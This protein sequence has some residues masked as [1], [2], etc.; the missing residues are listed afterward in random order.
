MKKMLLINAVF[1][2]LLCGFSTAQTKKL[3]SLL[4]L[5]G[6][7]QSDLNKIQL[8]NQIA[9][10]YVK[11]DN[12][13]AIVYSEMSLKLCSKKK[14]SEAYHLA[15]EHIWKAL[16]DSG[17]KFYEGSIYPRAL[18]LYTKALP[19]SILSNKEVN[20]GYAYSNIGNV[21]K[22]QGNYVKAFEFYSKSL[23]IRKKINDKRT[24][25]IAYNN[26]GHVYK[27]ISDQDSYLVNT[28]PGEKLNKALSCYEYALQLSTAADDKTGIQASYASIA[29]IY[30]S[31]K[32]YPLALE[33]HLKSLDIAL[34]NKGANKFISSAY[35]NIG[36]IYR[37]QSRDDFKAEKLNPDDRLKLMFECFESAR[38][39]AEKTSDFYM[40]KEAYGSL[41]AYFSE[42]GKYQEAYEYQKK[43]KEYNDSIY[44]SEN[45][46][47]LSAI[48]TSFEAEKREIQFSIEKEKSDLLHDQQLK[49]KQIVY[50]FEKQAFAQK[51]ENDK[52]NI[53]YREQEKRKRLNEGFKRKKQ[54]DQM[55]KV[56]IKEVYQL[57]QK[58]KNM[59]IGFIIFGLF[60]VLLFSFFIYRRFR[61][62]KKQNILIEKQKKAVETQKHLVEEKNKE[63]LDS[64]TYAKRIQSAILPQPKLVKEYFK[65]S[66][67]LYKPKDIVAGDFYWFEVVDDLIFFA[68]ADCTGH[69]VPGALVSVVC[70]NALNRSVKEY[71]LKNPAEILDKTREVVI[72]E[73]EKSDEDVKDGMDISLCTVNMNTLILNWS[74]AHNPLW[75]LR[76]GEIIEYKADKQPI[77]KF[78]HEKPFTNHRIELLDKDEI[79][80]ATDGFQD[81]FGGEKGKKFKASQMKELLILHAQQSME[82]KLK[83]M[84]SSFEAWRNE[85][86][87]VDDVCLIGVRF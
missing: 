11:K 48:F 58:R 33:T 4:Q 40:K 12:K 51:S 25:S 53:L 18:D 13:K 68:A 41:A 28:S 44:N 63:I 39:Y 36:K 30:E 37:T 43:F 81:Q 10:C 6:K 69:G 54:L 26:L 80:I 31:K 71:N 78:A 42:T 9:A 55:E 74:G 82:N 34:K 70:H 86:E 60:L 73:F 67:I 19:Y 7:K 5:T 49:Q 61:H 50:E 21:F 59:V 29:N 47:K 79:Y 75:I 45:S 17:V 23:E 14:Y 35:N 46:D 8:Y 64:I 87:Q 83:M 85:L 16:N 38:E 32:M 3:D 22:R 27:D 72:S 52:Q 76:D 56:R 77:G 84:D 57:N 62:T 1:G 66:F 20:I 24:L 2:F 15:N 65:E